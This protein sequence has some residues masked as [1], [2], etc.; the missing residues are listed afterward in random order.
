MT[1]I[2]EKDF[3]IDGEK[4]KGLFEEGKK[5]RLVFANKDGET[6]MSMVLLW[7]VILALVLWP[8]FVFG[9]ALTIMSGGKVR[10]E[11]KSKK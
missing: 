5:K 9:L 3:E 6:V 1:K 2:K 11:K 4:V 8:L 7:A 10:L